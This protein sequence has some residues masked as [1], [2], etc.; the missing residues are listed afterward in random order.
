MS[1]RRTD[2]TISS[3]GGAA[4]ERAG[5]R[6]ALIAGRYLLVQ[7]LGRGGHGEV[8][9]A[10]DRVARQKVAVK[11]FRS[12]DHAHAA[13]VRREIAVLRMLRLP[14]VVTMLDEGFDDDCPFMVMECVDGAPFP[15]KSAPVS[16]DALADGAQRLLEIVGRI[17]AAGVIHRDLKPSNVLVDDDGRVT[18]LDF[19]LSFPQDSTADRLTMDFEF[20]GTPAYLAPEQ[21]T[22]DAVGPETDLFAVGVMLYEALVGS[23]P[24][25]NAAIRGMLA[26]RLTQRARPLAEA[27]PSVPRAVCAV[28]D[29]LLE[30]DPAARPHSAESVIQQ[31]RAQRAT[32][33][34][35]VARMGSDEPVRAV[36]EALCAG[37]SVDVIGPAG[38]GRT[39]LLDDVADYAC[40]SG[41]SVV[42][43]KIDR[44]PLSTAR[45]LLG[46]QSA[47]D[48][49]EEL[50]S[51]IERVSRA[52]TSRARSA[53]VLIDD[54]DKSDALSQRVFARC[55]RG[56]SLVRV[57]SSEPLV[58]ADESVRLEALSA[59]DIASIFAGPER[60]LH[61]R[62]DGAQRLLERTDGRA[63]SV[64]DELEAWVRA[65]LCRWAQDGR[66]LI[67]RVA[68]DRIALDARPMRARRTLRPPRSSTDP[69]L[70]AH[71]V[72]VAQWLDLTGQDATTTVLV[73]LT[74]EPRWQV[75]A[76]L[77]EL[78]AR[79]LVHVDR[80]RVV[81]RA[82]SGM[83]VEAARETRSAAHR[84]VALALP[85]GKSGRFLHLLAS[86]ANEDP[87]LASE[88][89]AEAAAR[90][91]ELARDGRIGPATVLLSDAL[92]SV[93]PLVES[94]VVDPTPLLIAWIE[95]ALAANTLQALDAVLYEITRL[96]TERSLDSLEQLVR[97]AIAVFVWDDRAASLIEAVQPFGDRRLELVRATVRVL[98][99]R[100]VSYE[101]ERVRVAES[102]AE[103][104]QDPS[105]R[106]RARCAQW[107]GRL[108]YRDGR[109]EEAAA[110]HRVAASI[111]PW[112][113][114]RV[115][116]MLDAASASMEAF[117]LEQAERDARAALSLA[118]E[119]RNALL[120]GRA[121][122]LL[123]AVAFRRGVT[124]SVDHELID[125][126]S[127]L[128]SSQLEALVCLN[129][130]AI[131]WAEGDLALS[132][133]LAE[134]AYHR[135]SAMGEPFGSLLAGALQHACGRPLPDDA[136]ASLV[137]SARVCTS[138]GV[139][140]QALALL[141]DAGVSVQLEERELTLLVAGIGQEHWH[142]RMELL[143]VH[144]ALARLRVTVAARQLEPA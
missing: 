128:G 65:G 45:S 129:E 14:G 17:H 63:R 75:E 62:S 56:V 3:P 12:G 134:R 19:G 8:W 140:L 133:S 84:R 121:E 131:A 116:S 92:R 76:A 103:L 42:R 6:G 96:N 44:A 101:A 125:A 35:A 135:W 38:A 122:W 34:R 106:A 71:L 50:S 15:A 102:V 59:R 141:A 23:L 28:V 120:E 53:F 33:G 137:A 83:G 54:C 142:Q 118:A 123:R 110:F 86:G 24:H 18:V 91:A 57:L 32:Y 119:S 115:V 111:E 1:L 58:Q 124:L 100:R 39:R 144:D 87:A 48:P 60:L 20:M 11:L 67:D 130:A 77:D 40:A 37:R 79:G 108:A 136:L 66:V 143:S 36:F 73:E 43:A 13:R 90:S 64:I 55:L 49:S 97:A 27:A 105:P 4:F 112:L 68:L 61:L 7:P 126:V 26:D 5:R 72:S 52:I 104:A 109:F 10:D 117:S 69:A 31:L 21:L 81:V 98:A 46:E 9:E 29:Q 114:Q 132:G 78:E 93:R 22:G 82:S 70:P 80:E 89:V 51:V 47:I 88:V 30:I 2:P 16:W 113:S 85:R 138:P 107:Q 95:L 99:A 139:G 25:A 94:R 127:A 74:R 41:T